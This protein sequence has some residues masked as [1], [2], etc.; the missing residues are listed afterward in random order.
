MIV[1]KL[2]ALLSVTRTVHC[3]TDFLD[4]SFAQKPP[5]RNTLVALLPPIQSLQAIELLLMWENG[6]EV[7]ERQI[8]L[9]EEEKRALGPAST[10]A[11][12]LA[13]WMNRYVTEVRWFVEYGGPRCEA[14]LLLGPTLSL[15]MFAS[16]LLVDVETEFERL[17][18]VLYFPGVNDALVSLIPF[19]PDEL[20]DKS[21]KETFRDP[22]EQS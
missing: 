22:F 4:H 12:L 5:H 11:G 18:D 1:T 10:A 14:V 6:F 20:F 7:Q 9:I 17:N 21:D 16:W 2:R 13:N 8:Q 3:M 19:P 15:Q